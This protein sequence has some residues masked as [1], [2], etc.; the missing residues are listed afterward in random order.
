MVVL[1]LFTAVASPAAE[2]GLSGSRA[3]ADVVVCGLSSSNSPALELGLSSCGAWP[4][5]PGGM[6]A[7]SRPEIEPVSPA[8]AGRFSTTGPP[9]KSSW[10]Y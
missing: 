5:L 9:G 10:S 1:G 6:W 7:L 3:S 2:L 8:L 4:S